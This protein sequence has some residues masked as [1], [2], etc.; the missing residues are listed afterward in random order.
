MR[1]KLDENLGQRGAELLIQ[2]GHDVITSNVGCVLRTKNYA[3]IPANQI[4]GRHLF[5]YRGHIWPPTIFDKRPGQG[6]LEGG[7]SRGQENSA[8]HH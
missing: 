5:L 3:R 1:L 6:S 2:S 7:D 4:K 8:L